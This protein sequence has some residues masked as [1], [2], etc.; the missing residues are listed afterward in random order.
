MRGYTA[1]ISQHRCKGP[2]SRTACCPSPTL[3]RKEL[4]AKGLI[5]QRA[6]HPT[7]PAPTG[8]LP[9]A[10][11]SASIKFNDIVCLIFLTTTLCN[12]GWQD[13]SLTNLKLVVFL[14]KI[15]HGLNTKHLADPFKIQIG[16]N[17]EPTIRV[18]T[19]LIK[20]T[21]GTHT[22]S[23]YLFLSRCI[24]IDMHLYTRSHSFKSPFPEP[25]G[26]SAVSGNHYLQSMVMLL[27]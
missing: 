2:D 20:D 26:Q 5:S 27:L 17:S 4:S 6:Q 14:Y 18:A 12:W 15:V 11:G 16:L 13:L 8:T 1:Q 25:K 22:S 7:D 19:H 3:S 10:P 24:Y 23:I 9:F 21:H